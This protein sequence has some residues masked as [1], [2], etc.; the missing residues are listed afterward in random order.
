MY[1]YIRG[2]LDGKQSDCVV[3]EAAG[4]GYRVYTSMSTLSRLPAAD[5][6]IKLYTHFSVREDAHI[7]YGFLTKEE[8]GMFEILLTVSGVGPKAALAMLS[9]VSP[10]QFGLAVLTEDVKLLTRAQ[11]VGSKLAQ[12]IV[13]ELRDKLA[14]D[15]AAGGSGGAFA[16]FGAGAAAD[17]G[18][19]G[20]LAER[21][22]FAE[23]VGAL[24][25]LGYSASEANHAVEAIY[26]DELEIEEIIRRALRGH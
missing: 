5:T 6:E 19:A 24:L 4:V 2:R 25:I 20:E 26:S 16:G 18:A 15:Q 13:F 3:V 17:A 22:K 7:L 1:A 23:A 21:G 11:G 9:A 12:K 10:S 14:K 8:L